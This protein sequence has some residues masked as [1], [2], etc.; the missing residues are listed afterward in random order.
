MAAA[1]GH[2]SDRAVR[3]EQGGSIESDLPKLVATSWGEARLGLVVSKSQSG[4][5]IIYKA[6][7]NWPVAEA[8]DVI[9]FRGTYEQID[10]WVDLH[11]AR[12]VLAAL[13]LATP[14]DAHGALP[15][16]EKVAQP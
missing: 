1:P 11:C 16:D 12:A 13:N 15:S 5:G 14:S 10:E 7:P 2:A 3:S 8:S 4:N 9:L 6:G